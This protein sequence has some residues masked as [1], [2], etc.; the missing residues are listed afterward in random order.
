MS[1][2]G[3][4][5]RFLLVW[6][7]LF[8]T[9]PEGLSALV[10]VEKGEPRAQIVLGSQHSELERLAAEDLQQYVERMSGAQLPIVASD[11]LPSGPVVLIGQ[12]R[13]VKDRL[14]AL[15]SEKHLGYD[16][17]ILK[18]FPGSLV[19]AGQDYT[20][21][22]EPDLRRDSHYNGNG[23][24]FAVFALL[25]ELGCRF[26]NLHPDGE[27]VPWMETIEI[28]ELDVVS[29]PDVALRWLWL[30]GNYVPTEKE[31][32]FKLWAIKN[33][34]GG[35]Q[36]PH[37]HNYNVMLPPDRYF[38][39]HPEYYAYDRETD[40]RTIMTYGDGGLCLSNPDVQ[41]I[42]VDGV[43]ERF[44]SRGIWAY[45]LS[46]NDAAPED[47]CECDACLL[48]DS[49]EANPAYL[50]GLQ[51]DAS[52]YVMASPRI[53]L[54]TRVLQFNNR[55]A[56]Q[57]A[58]TYPGRLLTYYADYTNMPGPPVRTDGTVIMPA[59]PAVLPVIVLDNRWCSI[60][61][62]DDPHCP[63]NEDFRWRL[64]GW[65]RV[66]GQWMS[67]EWIGQSF[68][69]P[70]P[71]YTLAGPRIRYFADLGGF[72]A[73]SGEIL[74]RSP[75]TELTLYVLAKML[76]DTDLDDKALI[77]EYFS[78]YF[79]EAADP[80]RR[81]YRRLDEIARTVE[82]H[83]FYVHWEQWTPE[84]LDELSDLL[85]QA[86]LSARQ[87]V[88]KRRLQTE[89][90]AL[91]AYSRFNAGW[92]A[93]R[94]WESSARSE[95]RDRAVARLD[96]GIAFIQEI[97]D[98]DIVD[99][100]RMS[101]HLEAVRYEVLNAIREGE[102]RAS[103]STFQGWSDQE[104]FGDLSAEY[105]EIASMPEWWKFRTV[106]EQAGLRERWFAADF[107]DSSWDAI[108][109]GEFWELQGYPDYDGRAWYRA[110]FAI[111][112]IARDRPLLLYFGAVDESAEVWINGSK[113]GQHRIGQSGW[114]KRFA[115][116]ITSFARPGEDNR[117]AV[118]VRD[119]IHM[120]GIWKS[121][122]LYTVKDQH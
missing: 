111:P 59:H 16:G 56:E 116:D 39:E 82:G 23:T 69:R 79:Q 20:L 3:R 99:D 54:A 25:E 45:S 51:T 91:T 47:W 18:T 68:R 43:R 90:K 52:Q 1:N 41:R 13:A 30:S 122:K 105:E 37:G 49:D 24:R 14:G 88:V 21:D 118:R 61:D 62:M 27:H 40:Q 120:G 2:A 85:S 64:D 110:E 65:R 60:H 109:I 70:T 108:K 9:V 38:D 75:D 48:M 8:G 67:R 100:V 80:M 35:A 121:V 73:Y 42:V 10:L 119:E 115:V 86:E 33:R 5:T 98:E 102:R 112:S 89:R 7:V 31:K 34:L 11:E 55:V 6:S 113:A 46:P 4:M 17:Y 50:S 58:Q 26:F 74:G 106:S 72:L 71:Q 114:D 83:D 32:A 96:S 94:E 84:L 95:D 28:G 117:I 92:F 77:E 44:D 53:G 63:R 97:E 101:R 19:V 12:S 104:T 29:R 66:A 15:L 87:E 22:R 81:Y 36:I 76:W 107:D 78:L 57:V 93:S 103:A